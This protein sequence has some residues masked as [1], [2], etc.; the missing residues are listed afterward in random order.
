MKQD[1]KL[2][3]CVFTKGQIRKYNFFQFCDHFISRPLTNKL[4]GKWRQRVFEDIKAT[5]EK[6]GTSTIIPVERVKDLSVEKFKNYYVKY[7]IP[8][9][10]EGAAK[11]WEA[12]N[13]WSPEYFKEVYGNDEVPLVDAFYLDK[14]VTHLKLKEIIDEVLKGQ[15]SYL[16]FYNL[17]HRHP[18]CYNEFDQSWL[19]SLKH[20]K[21]YVEF[22]QVFIG[23]A[24]S[25]TGMHNSHADNLFVQVYG[26]KEWVL[27]PNY[28][29]P[30]IDPP[31]TTG[32]TYRIAPMRGKNGQPFNAFYPDFE[33]YPLY[34]YIDGYNVVLKPGDVFYNPPYMWHTVRNNTDSIGIGF[35]WCSFSNIRKSYPFYYFLDLMAFRPLYF[36][37]YRWHKKDSNKEFLYA[38]KMYRKMKAKEEKAKRKLNKN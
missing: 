30:L 18:E 20:A 29:M 32:G 38:E 10:F 13:K 1:P 24:K 19:K 4:F 23:G 12:I 8:V 25:M 2:P 16:R 17:L 31:S 34:Q 27:Y 26:E 22:T 35:R 5:L 3:A 9:V 14:G 15:N 6:K 36:K 28:F 33:T 37:A 7:G 21:S 11:D